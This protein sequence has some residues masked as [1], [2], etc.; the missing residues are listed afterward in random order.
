MSVAGR[1]V[2]GLAGP[3][4]APQEREWLVR[5][6]PAGVILFARNAGEGGAFARLMAD[7][8][9][10]LPPGGEICA[11][12]EGGAVAFLAAVA[13]RPPAARTLGDLDRPELTERVH[14]ETGQRLRDLGLDRVLAPCCDVLREPRN[15]VIGARSFGADAGRV[16]R[17]AVAAARGLCAA[18][19]HGCA[20]HWP[21]HGGTAVDTHDTHEAADGPPDAADAAPF[22]A[23]LDAGLDAVMVAHLPAAPG[24][25]PL[26]LDAA[27][28]AGLR[29]RLP[30]GAT[31][32][33][34]DVSMG[35]LR[36]PLARRGVLAGDGA[37]AGL[38]DPGR[39][40]ASWLAAI[41]AAG[42]DRLLLRGIP[43]RALPVDG[44]VSG[45]EPAPAPGARAAA[46][47]AGD[48]AVEARR[49]AAAAC[50]AD[51]APHRVLWLDATA[52]DRL[53]DATALIEPLHR[54]WP[55]VVRLDAS[56]PRLAA[57]RPYARLLV[58]SHRPLTMTQAGLLEP[59]LA[60][61]GEGLAAGHPSLA[62]DLERLAGPGWTFG[63]L[64]DFAPED[65]APLLAREAG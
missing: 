47:D 2:V 41:A 16:A 38:V 25:P 27:G 1:L 33:C 26:G 12:H 3:T 4:L 8:R 53:G 39:L 32:W 35:A 60:A 62:S 7:L 36:E 55:Q 6:Q 56:T 5:W 61:T 11:D 30:R 50:P 34:D 44:V 65:L 64:A 63:A 48:G 31:L 29:A 18:G 14:R 40:T 37:A 45:P 52:G 24:R 15:P 58:T 51:F 46:P 17:H 13:G 19:L 28:L 10:A 9:D 54:A 23:A 42:A 21:G 22:L 57:D 20:K 49:R 43:W 59:L